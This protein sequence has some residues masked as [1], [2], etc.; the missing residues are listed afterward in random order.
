MEGQ[1]ERVSYVLIV[2]PNDF[3]TYALKALMACNEGSKL[4][5]ILSKCYIP[6]R[7]MWR[8][9]KRSDLLD[10]YAD[11]ALGA[12]KRLT[13]KARREVHAGVVAKRGSR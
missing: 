12:V 2:S 5:P 13:R 8:Q 9:N 10:T 3:T 7:E 4:R 11:A 6:V 1:K